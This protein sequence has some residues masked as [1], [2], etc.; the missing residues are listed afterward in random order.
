MVNLSTLFDVIPL[1]MTIAFVFAVVGVAFLWMVM[2]QIIRFPVI[3]IYLIVVVVYAYKR[4]LVY[5]EYHSYQNTEK[6]REQQELQERENN[7]L[8][9]SDPKNAEEPVKHYG[10][11]YI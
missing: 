2:P 5:R 11:R 9:F 8:L 7:E 4:S 3:V 1:P 10:I 6:R